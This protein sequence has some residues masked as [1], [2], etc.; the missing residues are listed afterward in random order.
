LVTPPVT[1]PEFFR[2]ISVMAHSAATNGKITGSGVGKATGHGNG[3]LCHQANDMCAKEQEALKPCAPIPIAIV[4][5]ACRFS[6][7]V[8]NP[9]QLW[10]LCAAGKDGWS[11]IPE[12]RFD[13][14]SLYHPN[15]EKVGRVSRDTFNFNC[16]GELQKSQ[17]LVRACY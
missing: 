15:N 5:M 13:V 1:T 9:T 2:E 7:N 12:S 8:T 4:G 6:G 10:D 11:R 16:I 3:R 17:L 14:K